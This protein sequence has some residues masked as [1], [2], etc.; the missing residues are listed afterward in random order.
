MRY[1]F[2]DRIVKSLHSH[3]AAYWECDHRENV[4]EIRTIDDRDILRQLIGDDAFDNVGIHF[5]A[6]IKSAEHDALDFVCAE[7]LQK[8]LEIAV[9]FIYEIFARDIVVLEEQHNVIDL[10]HKLCSL[11][12][13]KRAEIAADDRSLTGALLNYRV[14]LRGLRRFYR[15]NFVIHH[16]VKESLLRV[17]RFIVKAKGAEMRAVIGNKPRFGVNGV[18]KRG[19]IRISAED[20]RM[21]PDDFVINMF[22]Y[23]IYIEAADRRQYR[24]HV[25]VK[26]RL[27]NILNSVLNA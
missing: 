23:L 25:V 2:N 5:A 21:L 18:Q 9:K 3:P 24:F 16:A 13:I 14:S 17:I 22:Q 12:Q 19:D 4:S 10:R 15:E 11:Q 8:R 20:F 6:V 26:K 27:V 1:D 7:C